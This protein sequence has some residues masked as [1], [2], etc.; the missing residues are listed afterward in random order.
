MK[1]STRQYVQERLA[2]P[3]GV[4]KEGKVGRSNGFQGFHDRRLVFSTEN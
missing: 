4:I 1:R 3:H 2:A